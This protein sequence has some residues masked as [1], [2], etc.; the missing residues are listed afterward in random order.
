MDFVGS[1]R[2]AAYR[3][4]AYTLP[5]V[6]S[7]RINAPCPESVEEIQPVRRRTSRPAMP[8]RHA[9]PILRAAVPPAGGNAPACSAS[10]GALSG[11]RDR[12][13]ML[14]AV[15]A[16]ARST[17]TRK[18]ARRAR[19]R[20]RQPHYCKDRRSCHAATAKKSWRDS[21]SLTLKRRAEVPTGH[22]S[23][24]GREA[25]SH[26]SRRTNPRM[27]HTPPRSRSNCAMPASICPTSGAMSGPRC[28]GLR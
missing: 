15:P 17:N 27:K 3:G 13:R 12:R 14:P 18:R 6:S 8:H 25:P 28:G 16:Q 4:L 19:P 1:R 21:S 11:D 10:C 26:R 24:R 23:H 2:P 22:L 7:Q 5:T 20:A 9:V